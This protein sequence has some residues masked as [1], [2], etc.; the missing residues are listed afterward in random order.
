MSKI[1]LHACTKQDWAMKSEGAYKASSLD[2]DKFIHCSEQETFLPVA[3]LLW[4]GRNDLLLLFIDSDKVKSEIK[5]ET[6]SQSG[7]VFPHIYGPLNL[8]SVIKV[9]ELLP[10]SQGEF[11]TEAIKQ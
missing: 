4:K 9:K 2:S 3:N 10:N 7:M 5:Y 6:D 11:T 1:I 8:D